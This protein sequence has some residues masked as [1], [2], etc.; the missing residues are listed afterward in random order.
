MLEEIMYYKYYDSPLG[1]LQ[2][3]ASDK[4]LV[5]VFPKKYFKE[6]SENIK[7]DTGNIILLTAEKQLDEYFS[8]KRKE[9][10]IKLDMRG[11][12]F[13]IK[14][15]QQLQK[16]SYGDTISYGKQAQMTG[17]KKKA[18]AVGVANGRNPL[19][20][21]VPCHRVIG[22]NGALVGFGGGVDMK[23]KLLELEKRFA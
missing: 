14:A 18:R 6:E 1:K 12:I 3:V 9:F 17:D 11:T 19:M 2:L 20:I 22:A 21:V 4:G 13:Q 7:E 10:D 15:W 16:I 5:A 8:G 23:Q